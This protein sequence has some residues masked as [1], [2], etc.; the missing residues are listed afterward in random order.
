MLATKCEA[1]DVT[2]GCKGEQ[3]S[4]IKAH[5]TI[6]LVAD[7]AVIGIGAI[8]GILLVSGDEEINQLVC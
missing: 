4:G 3:S 7:L 8:G 1:D 5:L 6:L 2:A